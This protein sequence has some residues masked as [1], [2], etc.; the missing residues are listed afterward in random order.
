[1]IDKDNIEKA[2]LLKC[3]TDTDGYNECVKNEE[4]KTPAEKAKD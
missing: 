1:M 2:R 3:T 4:K